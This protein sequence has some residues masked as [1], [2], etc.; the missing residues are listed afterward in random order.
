VRA[1]V[2][3]TDMGDVMDRPSLRLV[4]H[5]YKARHVSRSDLYALYERV[6][7]LLVVETDLDEMI[8]AV[9]EEVG[10]GLGTSRCMIGLYPADILSYTFQYIWHAPGA[11]RFDRIVMEGADRNPSFRL[12][13]S[14]ATYRCDDT[15]ED[16][17]VA[18]MRQFYRSY[19][20]RSSMFCGLW[21]YG[22]W[23]GAFGVHQCG[24]PRTW[25]DAEAQFL[26]RAAD[27]IA[28]AVD[29]ISCRERAA[30]LAGAGQ[31]QYKVM[32]PVSQIAPGKEQWLQKLG[33]TAAERRV[34]CLV[35]RGQ[36]NTEI[37]AELNLSRR[38]V[39]CHITSMLSKLA[40][41]NR[42]ELARVVL[43]RAGIAGGRLA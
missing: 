1:I 25:K 28:M 42:V 18:C 4:G 39:E 27:Q 34:L 33:V 41:R 43:N 11:P 20:I 15:E 10:R 9:V 21:R 7:A 30:Q 19:G 35:A 5:H 36:T 13:L 29:L 8:E 37:A 3:I 14:G 22:N 6:T 31:H 32:A 38:T 40:L 24:Q 12:M 26:E 23:W 2:E 16:S 17:R